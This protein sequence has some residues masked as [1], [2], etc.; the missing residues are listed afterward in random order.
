MI[1]I[2]LKICNINKIEAGVNGQPYGKFKWAI[3]Q[4]DSQKLKQ[5]DNGFNIPLL[6]GGKLN[7]NPAISHRHVPD[8][9]VIIA[10][11]PQVVVTVHYVNVV[12]DPYTKMRAGKSLLTVNCYCDIAIDENTIAVGKNLTA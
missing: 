7:D 10:D 4:A 2:L 8:G 6:A 3:S 5:T 12:E 11:W 1:L 9:T